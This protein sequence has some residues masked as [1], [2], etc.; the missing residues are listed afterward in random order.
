MTRAITMAVQIVAAQTMTAQATRFL[1]SVFFKVL[2]LC[3]VTI[4]SLHAAEPITLENLDFTSV[5]GGKLEVR[6]GFSGASVTPNGYVIDNPARMVFDFDNTLSALEQKKYELNQELVKSAVVLSSGGRTRLILNLHEAVAYE[7]T[8][9]GNELSILVGDGAGVAAPTSQYSAPDSS[10]AASSNLDSSLSDVDF[11]RG[12]AGEGLVSIGLT[13]KNA[14]VDISQLGNDVVLT[15]YRTSLP[16]ALDRNLNVIDFATPVKNVDTSFDGQATKVVIKT[17]GNYDYLAYQADD[18]YVVSVKPLTAEEEAEKAR[19]FEY[20]GEKLSLNFQDIDVRALLQLMADF[21]D[22]NLVA[23]DG[24]D[25]KITLR[26]ENVPWDQALDIIL[27]SQGLDKRINGNVMMVAPAVDIAEIERLQVEANK[28]VEE[29]APLRTEYIRVHYAD[30]KELF[31]LFSKDGGGEE[32]STGSILS[33]RGSVIVDERTNTIILTETE[34]KISNFRRIMKEI[35]IPVRQ[36][37]IEARIVIANTDFRKEL[38]ARWSVQGEGQ[39]AGNGLIGTTGSLEGLVDPYNPI[40][41]NAISGGTTLVNAEALNVDL[42]V[43]NPN[44]A[45]ALELITDNFFI[46]LELSALENSGFGEIV[47]QPK[48]LTGDKQEAIIE[49]GT[50]IPYLSDSSSGATEIDFEDAT[51][52]LKVTPQITPDNRVIM[53]LEIQQDSVGAFVPSGIGGV[54]PSIDLTHITTRALVGD[55]QTLVLGGIF[56][57]DEFSGVEKVPFFGD[58]P[59]IGRIFRKDIGSSTKREIL[60]FITPKIISDNLVDR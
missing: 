15:F 37:E 19:E 32:G 47:S 49:S 1:A 10:T 12:E 24:V 4:G 34:E 46:D 11:R 31:D 3:A 51:L 36:V 9:V 13:D 52:M 58:L 48:V 57:S 6:V 43:A 41:G 26:L 60:I 56:Q 21:T 27:K 59:F 16:S 17:T 8:A 53:D 35:D 28:Q 2:A 29:L 54:I 33:A 14:S 5:G 44:G 50:Q 23:S 18:R 25:G 45:F 22:F 42:G 55:G 30:A 39:T 38:G 7:L 40:A 20:T